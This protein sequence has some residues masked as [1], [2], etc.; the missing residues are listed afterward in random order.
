MTLNIKPPEYSNIP[1]EE[2]IG[3]TIILLKFWYEKKEFIRL[4]YFIN[5]ETIED[6]NILI[7]ENKFSPLKHVLRIILYDQPRITY[8]PRFS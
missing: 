8:F 4:G 5:N 3:V 1:L 7:K 2:I 6:E